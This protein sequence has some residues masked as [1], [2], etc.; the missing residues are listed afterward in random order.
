MGMISDIKTLKRKDPAARHTLEILLSHGGLHAV[1]YYRIAHVL[2][3][4]KLKTMA[5]MMSNFARFL[6]GVE[7]HPAAKIGKNFIID[8]GSGVV[9]GET[10]VVG[11]NVLIYHQVT[12]GGTGNDS[13][14][15]RH[16]SICDDVMIAAGAKIL[17]NIRVGIGAKI[18]ANSVVLKDVPPYATAVGMPARIIE[19]KKLT[20]DECSLADK[21]K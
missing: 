16:P 9:I 2:W 14:H 11:S 15:K 8:H 10:A 19:G 5:R 12:L 21:V 6:T 17:G 4:L 1:W 20:E 18:G 3:K 13:D 7:I